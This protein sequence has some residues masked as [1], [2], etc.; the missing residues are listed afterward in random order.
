M[1]DGHQPLTDSQWQ[2]IVCLLP[3]HRKRR[4]CLRQV[5]DAMGYICRTGCQW[6]CLPAC[7]PPWP[8][9]YYYFRRW[10]ADGPL[11]R[12]NQ[13]TARTGW[14]KVADRP[15]HWPW[16][17]RK[18]SSWH[19]ACVS[20]GGWMP[21]N[22]STAAS[23]KCAATRVG[24]SGKRPYTPP[25][26]TIAGRLTSYCLRVQPCDRLGQVGCVLC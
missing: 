12:L 22:A 2:V 6:R 3:I 18:V 13:A 9:V 25:T 10:Q 8:V 1:V 16:S 19:R 15:H 5:L 7:F 24:V 23:V 20:S 17:M 21:T 11:A 4:H 14:H 26:G